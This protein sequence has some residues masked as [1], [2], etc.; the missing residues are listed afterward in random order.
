MTKVNSVRLGDVNPD[1]WPLLDSILK[2]EEEQ[3]LGSKKMLHCL[4]EKNLWS[5]LRPRVHQFLE[6]VKEMYEL[7]IY[8]MG[9]KHYAQVRDPSGTCHVTPHL[10]HVTCHVTCHVTTPDPSS[11]PYHLTCHVTLTLHLPPSPHLSCHLSCHVTPG[12]EEAA[13]SHREAFLWRHLEQRQHLSPGE[14]PRRSLGP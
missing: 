9:D 5:K 13:R 2:G 12:D 11:S 3:G 1:H 4:R 7:H 14:E 8:T 6:A 10:P